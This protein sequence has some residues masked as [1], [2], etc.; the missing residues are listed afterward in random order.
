MLGLENV[1]FKGTF[2]SY[3]Q[4]V[5]DQ[6][7]TYLKDKKIHIVAAPG[8]GKTILGLELIC[9]LKSP[10]I[11]LS[12]T[13]T[14]RTQWQE[15]FKESFLSKDEKI[16]DYF[17][18]DLRNVQFLNS[19]TYQALYS[20]ISKI[21]TSTT[22]EEV[23]YSQIDLFKLIKEKGIQTICLDEAHHL[24]NEWQKA[25]EVFIKELGKDITVISL[26]ATPPYD[27]GLN[28][29]NRYI[30]VC[31]EI[32]DEIFVPELVYEKTL[33][34]HQD[35]ILFN[36]PSEE[37]ANSFQTHHIHTYQALNQIYNMPF[38][39]DLPDIIKE[40]YKTDDAYI[41]ENFKYVVALMILCNY[42]G[43]QPSKH[44]FKQLTNAN[45]F[46]ALNKT[47]AER[48]IQFLLDGTLVSE[49]IKIQITQIL[50]EHGLIERKKLHLDLSDKLKRN[51]ISSV[52]KLK[53]ISTIVNSEAEHL[54]QDLR[55]LILTDYIKK[56]MVNKI[57]K[58]EKFSS[59]SV[60]SIFEEIRKSSNISM[61]CLSGGL[62]ILPLFVVDR[63]KDYNP[64]DIKYSVQPF[65]NI[66]YG[67]VEFKGRNQDKVQMVS[68]MF[69]DGLI[70]VLI[71]TQALLGEGWDSPCI[72]SLI[73]ASYV[74]SFMLSNQMRGRAIRSYYKNP[75]KTAN[76][77]HLVTVEP[78]Y[79]FEDSLMKRLHAKLEE[80]KEKI[81]SAD[82]ET[83]VRRFDCFV[84][85]NYKTGGIES[86]IE[87]IT[88]LNPPYTKASYE[89]INR[90]MLERSRKREDMTA[91]WTDSL[92]EGT[93][94][95]LTNTVPKEFK[96]PSFT[97]F[98]FISLILCSAVETSFIVLFTNLLRISMNMEWKIIS[99][100]LV[101]LAMGIVGFFMGKITR[102][103]LKHSSPK[104][105]FIGLSKAI[106][107]TLKELE[108]IQNG[109]QVQVD[110][111]ELDIGI[112]F[113]LR[114]G[115]IHEQNIFNKAMAELLSP[116]DNPRYII[117]KQSLFSKMMY[118]YSFACPSIIAKNDGVSIL[119]HQLKSVLGNMQA[120]YVYSS[121]GRRIALKCRK[122]S[123]ITKNEQLIIKRQKLSKF[124]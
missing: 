100:F 124:E 60:V 42:A 44:I 120:V 92:A 99:C 10:C 77:W 37:E 115:S 16:E 94:T 48:A 25:L 4:R 102:F 86:G 18:M 26:T 15:R 112:E 90:Q 96:V 12:P 74:G 101:F 17:S 78:N 58:D 105:S 95:I 52:G 64:K 1:K 13:T 35:Y 32:D 85:P 34:P 57:G 50:Q 8:S 75:N 28:E 84:G 45:Y 118:R 81:H 36:Y 107:S 46:P 114:N 11:I 27:A 121:E 38:F 61:G 111:D 47:Y 79:I 54:K 69:E 2:R 41:Y 29:W 68:K 119:N 30:S 7:D 23:D 22:D 33:C 40:K 59:I 103:I 49:E 24:Q 106:L 122:K 87:R 63:L 53:S 82:F 67:R 62:V 66:E 117:V 39:K 88:I 31:G 123:F 43:Y 65:E 97:Y 3:Q 93:K 109:A 70:Q 89:A 14:I 9:R 72:N 21:A 51:L 110:S 20:A 116:I 71:G 91:N 80:D 73:M 56:E 6:A 98:N 76:I 83:L 104:K 19:I 5:L 113:H 55:M 108:L